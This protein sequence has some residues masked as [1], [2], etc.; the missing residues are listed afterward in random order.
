M[1]RQ[2]I[3]TLSVLS[4]LIIMLT[5]CVKADFHI[6]VN[7]DSSAELDY[8]IGISAQVAGLM[9]AGKDAKDP[10][11]DMRQQFE[12]QGFT[13]I[14]YREGDYIGINAKKH[15][16]DIKELKSIGNL[17]P[18][19]GNQKDN[20]GANSM[21]IDVQNGL[22][23]TTYSYKGA[24]DLSTLKPDANDTMGIQKA[25]LNQMDLKVTLTLPVTAEEQNASR[26]LD[27]KKTYQWDLLPGSNNE[28]VLKTKVLNVT[29]IVVLII[30][31]VIVLIVALTV[32]SRRKKKAAFLNPPIAI[33]E[34]TP[35]HS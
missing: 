23:Y 25:M 20:S 19:L 31:L 22:F 28:I 9:A 24:L 10:L 12:Q 16:S 8:K 3:L 15:Q 17:N 27:D 18:N 11:Q 6:T 14:Q 13:V 35:P 2:K 30:V 7:K 32:I 26:V 5:G 33:E 21:N 29:N 1:N 4:F 34:Q